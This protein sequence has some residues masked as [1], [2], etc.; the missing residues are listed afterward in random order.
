MNLFLLAL[1]RT[2][3]E[4]AAVN[5]SLRMIASRLPYLEGADTGQHVSRD[6][7]LVASWVAHPPEL[8]GG[9][10]YCSRQ[11]DLLALYSGRPIVAT[12]DGFDGTAPLDARLYLRRSDDWEQ[13]LDGRYVIVRCEEGREVT[14]VSDRGG[15]YRVFTAEH[16]D[17][18]WI[19]NN[20]HAVALAAGSTG[21]DE[22]ALASLLT[23]GWSFGGA[24]LRANVTRLEPNARHTFRSDPMRW[25]TERRPAFIQAAPPAFDAR[26]AAQVLTQTTA[27]FMDWPQRPLTVSVTG[28]RDSRLT[29]A[30]AAR[31]R[32]GFRAKTSTSPHEAGYPNSADVVVARKLCEIAGI[33]HHTEIAPRP[34][35]LDRTAQALSLMTMGSMSVGDVGSAPLELPQGA[36]ELHITGQ[37]GEIARCYYGA[38]FDTALA[39]SEAVCKHHIHLVPAPLANDAGLELVRRWV[40][41]WA[42]ARAEEGVPVPALGDAFYLEESMGGW[43]AAG[44]GTYEYWADTVCPLWTASLAPLMLALPARLRARDGFHNLVLREISGELWAVKFAGVSPRWPSLRKHQL[45]PGAVT[46]AHRRL[47]QINAELLRRAELRR[48]RN[49]VEPVDTIVDAQR[50]ACELVASFPNHDAWRIL[51]RGRVER[52]LRGDPREMHPRSRDQISRVLTIFE[53]PQMDRQPV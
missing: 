33:E 36:L 4:P 39:A 52:I 32:R 47:R 18:R 19:G 38:A 13:R 6:G 48:R 37:G 7:R 1:A 2:R 12:D 30:A 8:T 26:Q 50:R 5:H 16:G 24:S 34:S 23:F 43:A 20:A 46:K 35:D 31:S 10:T 22:L 45:V 28:G 3:I 44:H 11:D 14:V 21:F 40:R 9:I 17:V 41:E 15:A 25:S 42:R 49:P 51:D 27:A 29:F 53:R